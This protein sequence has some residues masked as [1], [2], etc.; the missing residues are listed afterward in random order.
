MALGALRTLLVAGKT[1]ILV[2]GFGGADD[3]IKTVKDGKMGATIAQ[4]PAQISVIGV[5]TA[6]K[7]PEEQK[8]LQVFRCHYN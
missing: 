5:E 6:D 4:Q 2:V 8:Y 1:G 7:V 3:G